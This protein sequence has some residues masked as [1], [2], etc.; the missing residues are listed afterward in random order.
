MSSINLYTQS[1][2][3]K[4]E[5]EVN[6]E[7]F[8]VK[9]ANHMLIHSALIRQGSNARHNIAHT[10]T[11]G[12]V[13]GGGAKSR[14]QKGS[15]RSRQGG[16]RNIHMRGGGVCFGPRNNRNFFLMMPKKQ[17]RKALFSTLT[18][19]QKDGQVSALESFD[20]Q[21][22]KTKIFVAML[23]KLPLSGKLL[24]AIPEKNKIFELCAR[25]IPNVKVILV[26]N[27]NIK[28]VLEYD[29]VLFLKEALTKAEEIFVSK[30]TK[31]DNKIVKAK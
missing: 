9:N 28:D 2:E 3:K 4:G 19:K 16:I 20:S 24:I 30:K 11:R 1:G 10:K 15:G 23:D 14:P 31:T 5:I 12:E 29:N 27:L 7:I 8:N 13:R 17:R 26:Q 21:E 6:D 22:I 18:L 25:N